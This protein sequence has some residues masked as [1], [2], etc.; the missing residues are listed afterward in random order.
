MWSLQYFA[1]F[2][3]ENIKKNST[4][5]LSKIFIIHEFNILLYFICNMPWFI[6]LWILI[7]ITTAQRAFVEDGNI[8]EEA[9]KR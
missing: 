3:Y 9:K 7:Q 1:S 6:Y 4:S 2:H 8:K 5:T